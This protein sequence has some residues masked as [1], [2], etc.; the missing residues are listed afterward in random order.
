MNE[1]RIFVTGIEGFIGGY[2]V[3]KLSHPRRNRVKSTHPHATA[4][5]I[6]RGVLTH[7]TRGDVRQRAQV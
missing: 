6:I 5:A 1:M 4:R 3:S 7:L 2:I